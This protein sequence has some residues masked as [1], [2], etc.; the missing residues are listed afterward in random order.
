MLELIA[1]EVTQLLFLWHFGVWSLFFWFEEVG[2]DIWV[3]WV[4]ALHPTPASRPSS[5]K[6]VDCVPPVEWDSS[7]L[8]PRVAMSSVGRTIWKKPRELPGLSA[9]KSSSRSQ[10]AALVMCSISGA[11][12]CQ[13]SCQ[14]RWQWSFSWPPSYAR[15][16]PWGEGGMAAFQEKC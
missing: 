10:E 13:V 5:Y 15:R 16:L 8:L 1:K 14:K 12:D 2:M 7:C 3:L 6:W 11:S 4:C 9:R